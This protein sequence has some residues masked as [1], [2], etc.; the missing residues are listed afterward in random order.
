MS[1][2]P[3]QR[4]WL[5]GRGS[6]G[7]CH[8]RTPGGCGSR[9]GCRGGAGCDE[10][11]IGGEVVA[12]DELAGRGGAEGLKVVP[13]FGCVGDCFFADETL[14]AM[15]S[16]LWAKALRGGGLRVTDG[17][18]GHLL[19]RVEARYADVF[20]AEVGWAALLACQ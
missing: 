9:G 7:R 16:I 3:V 11:L 2:D 8:G 4:T 1:L 12:V 13:H 14:S 15:V 10:V 5:R 18:R 6:P 19:F 17:G 20:S